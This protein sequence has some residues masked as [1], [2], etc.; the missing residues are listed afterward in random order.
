[1]WPDQQLTSTLGL[2]QNEYPSDCPT[3]HLQLDGVQDY[4]RIRS[5]N[6]KHRI[7][8]SYRL[9]SGN[10]GSGGGTDEGEDNDATECSE[11]HK[12]VGDGHKAYSKSRTFIFLQQ[13]RSRVRS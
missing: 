7:I 8:I 4:D 3:G 9:A 2:P 6:Y 1:M 10:V 5:P 13:V 12:R 11:L